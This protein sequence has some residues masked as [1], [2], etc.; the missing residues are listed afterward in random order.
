MLGL[1][2]LA[3]AQTVTRDIK[4]LPD[5]DV[6]I[7]VYLNIQPDCTS[8]TLPTIRLATPPEHGKVAIKKAKVN[9]TNYKQCLALEVTGYVGFYH[10]TP[11]YVGTDTFVLEVK[12]PEGRTE[13]QMFT[14]TVG[15]PAAGQRT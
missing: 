7:G 3:T 13:T 14:V 4:G 10:S 6:Q 2:T 15:N 12:F 1:A 9:A 5:K 11:N 8:G